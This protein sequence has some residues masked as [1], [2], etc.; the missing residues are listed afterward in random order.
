MDVDGHDWELILALHPARLHYLHHH[1][2][3][4]RLSSQV[5]K[6]L[7]YCNFSMIRFVII[8]EKSGKF[9]FHAPIGALLQQ[10]ICRVTAYNDRKVYLQSV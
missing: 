4:I 1:P 3:N 2:D 6:M 9:H 5:E 7:N 8:S 10:V